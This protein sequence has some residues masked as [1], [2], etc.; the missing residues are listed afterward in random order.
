MFASRTND[1]TTEL[2]RSKCAIR[3]NQASTFG[4]ADGSQATSVVG[5][6]A[7]L[8][9]LPGARRQIGSLRP[10]QVPVLQRKCA[11]GA[12]PGPSGE[13]ESCKGGT[14]DAVMHRRKSV[15]P[16]NAQT[17]PTIVHEVLQSSGQ[18][19]DAQTRENMEPR[20][21]R[22]FSG[23]RIH[24]DARAAAS[25]H[26]VNAA[27]YAVGQDIVFDAGRYQPSSPTGRQLLAHELA[28][29]VQQGPAVHRKTDELAIGNAADPSEREADSMAEAA[30]SG[31]A[32]AATNARGLQISRLP[33]DAGSPQ[34]VRTDGGTA[35]GGSP[36]AGAG[37]GGPAAATALVVYA[38]GFPNIYNSVQDET[39]NKDWTPSSVDFSAT[40]AAAGGNTG[41]DSL[42]GLLSLISAAAPGSIKSLDLIGHANQNTFGLGGTITRAGGVSAT[43]GGT[44]DQAS[45]DA[46]V[47]DGTIPPLRSRFAPDATIT[48]YACNAAA[49]GTLLSAVSSAFQVC[50]RGFATALE[51][52]IIFSH[53]KHG[54]K[55]MSR[56]NVR[57]KVGARPSCASFPA[58]IYNLTPAAPDCS[59][60]SAGSGSQGTKPSTGTGA[61]PDAGTP[62]AQ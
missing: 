49:S 4:H 37:S 40:A 52:C 28:H 56:G 36:D 2:G 5:N 32:P 14:S 45:L 39:A 10:S 59:G 24:T 17:A 38:S 1:A 13:C 48:F 58:T 33:P 47:K 9:G 53:G 12:S 51:W 6:H 61:Q 23:V 16:A 60:V 62:P 19:L 31:L 44:I 8:L 35:N 42:Q 3:A 29:T 34:P 41:I 18:P 15:E 11:C 26:A 25:A 55:I 21:G 43:A 57:A 7:D 20:F 22:D 30:L 54:T 50:A 46:N 27:A